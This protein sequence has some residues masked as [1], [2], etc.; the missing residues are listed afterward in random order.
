MREF[1]RKQKFEDAITCAEMKQKMHFALN[2]EIDLI[3]LADLAEIALEQDQNQV[4]IRF[5]EKGIEN[6]MPL[7]A[8][9]VRFYS[10]LIRAH[11]ALENYKDAERFFQ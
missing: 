6:T 11:Y 4:A 10:I 3:T 1:K 2:Q 7:H 9:R 8:G 5:S